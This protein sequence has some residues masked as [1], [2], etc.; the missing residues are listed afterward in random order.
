MENVKWGL[1][2]WFIEHGEELIHPEDLKSF[3]SEASNCKVFECIDEGEYMTLRYNERCYRVKAA[4]F[5]PL[6]APKFYFGQKVYI[7][8]H[9]EEAVITDI[10][11]H[12]DR[13]QHY[14][15]V[16]ETA[17]AVS[18]KKKSKR[19]FEPELESKAL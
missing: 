14:Y 17:R 9:D 16:Q 4:L 10:L 8:K 5:C 19:Y 11:W 6:P 13:Q 2:P 15:F 3:R 18:G 12:Y 7:L 1:Y